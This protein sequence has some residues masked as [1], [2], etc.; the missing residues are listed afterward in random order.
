MA[1]IPPESKTRQ[2]D[3]GL[4]LP[5]M[6]VSARQTDDLITTDTSTAS[7]AANGEN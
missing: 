6:R 2:S 4:P 1:A 3:E 5:G 7:G